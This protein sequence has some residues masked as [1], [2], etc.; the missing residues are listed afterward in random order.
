MNKLNLKQ[1]PKGTKF[2]TINSYNENDIILE[3]YIATLIYNEYSK[4]EIYKSL[5][6]PENEIDSQFIGIVVQDIINNFIKLNPEFAKILTQKN[7]FNKL[8]FKTNKID[9]NYSTK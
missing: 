9:I 8:S 7:N 3:K 4:D 5:S 6:N 1:L 2:S